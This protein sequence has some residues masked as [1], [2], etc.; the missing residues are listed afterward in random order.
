M[1]QPLRASAALRTANG[2]G[3]RAARSA[4]TAL[5]LLA[6]VLA[7]AGCGGGAGASGGGRRN[8]RQ[9]RPAVT[10]AKVERKP[11][12]V[13]ILATGTIEPVQTANVGSQ[14]GGVVESY[15]IREGQDVRKGQ[16][17]IQLDPRPFRAALAQ[18][19]AQLARDRA[20]WRAAWLDAQRADKLLA[21]QLISQADHDKS[22]ATA[23]ALRGTVEADSAMAGIARLNL[24]F[25]SIRAPIAGRTGNL[26]VHVGD[27]VKAATSDPLVTVNQITPI[28]VRFTLAQDQIPQMQ[29]YRAAQPKVF[30]RQGQGDSLEVEGR[31]VFVDNAVDA[32]TGTLLLKG[33]LPNADG[34]LWPGEFVQV[35]LVLT[36]QPDAIV[37]PAPAVTSGQ[38]GTYV[39]VLNADSTATAR[40]VKVARTDDVSAVI[41]TGLQPGET[42]ITDGQF[43]IAPGARVLV[44]NPG[45]GGP[46]AGRAGGAGAGRDESGGRATRSAR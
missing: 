15:A 45:A 8:A 42:V 36:T 6:L 22:I 12:P 44:R 19:N 37:V 25:A 27:L 34:R 3:R 41:S 18:A 23:D 1:N 21:D 9:Q 4:A 43:R 26:N 31:L 24:D 39:Y 16:V 2:R 7:L 13:Q 32:A 29:R 46:G 28:R 10:V 33:E 35:R 14:V 40:P 38:Q 17:L 20:Q 5:M 11:M 30:V